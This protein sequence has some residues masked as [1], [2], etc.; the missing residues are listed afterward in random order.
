VSKES[1]KARRVLEDPSS[2]ALPLSVALDELTGGRHAAWEIESVLLFLASE[3]ALPDE[4]SREKLIAVTAARSNPAYLWDASIFKNLCAAFNSRPA[5]PEVMEACSPAEAAW[6]VVELQRI[7][8]HYTGT[9]SQSRYGDETA[10]YVAGACAH[11]G[12]VVLPKELS[13]A[14][15]YMELFPTASDVTDLASRIRARITQPR[16]ES[17]DEEDPVEVHAA[18]LFEIEDY[19]WHMNMELDKQLSLLG[20]T[21]PL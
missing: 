14:Q 12:L 2:L 10:A 13:F 9:I 21:S 7:E 20:A 18:K 19:V 1:A 17:L 5:M 11:D 4:D 16:T 3:S 6:T 8:A 15:D